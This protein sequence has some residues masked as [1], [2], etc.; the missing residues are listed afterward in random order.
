MSNYKFIELTTEGRVA[1][2]TLNRPDKLNAIND[3][4]LN[5][6][7][8]VL[9]DIERTTGLEVVIFK[10]K[11]RCFSVGQDLSGV[12][13]K[14]VMPPDPRPKPYESEV[15]DYARRQFQR[16]RSIVDYPRFTIAQ[17]H[18]YCLGAGLDLAMCCKV[19]IASEDAVFGDPSIRLGFAPHN[20]LWTWRVGLKKAKELLLT[21]NYIGAK[22]AERIGL[23]MRVEPADK[24]DE[25]V[26]NE[27]LTHLKLDTMGGFDLKVSWGQFHQSCFDIAGLSASWRMATNMYALSA[28]QR[29]TR[30]YIDRG[31]FNFYK[32]RD[33]K[34]Y[35]SAISERDKP[36]EAYSPIPRS[37]RGK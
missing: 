19:V 3:D 2:V 9:E 25:V 12:N 21:G 31:G 5:D 36:F 7:M 14:E 16:W 22:E 8:Q 18:G 34:G 6:L 4:L 13:T 15:F 26:K 23:V 28:I 37:K 27:S 30:S 11:G 1:T 33:E 29:P 20:P 17:V 35:K 24:I 10:G 32:I